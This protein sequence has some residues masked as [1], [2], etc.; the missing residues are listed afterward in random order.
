MAFVRASVLPFALVAITAASNVVDLTPDNFDDVVNGDKPAFVEFYAP[1]CGHCKS[2]A[3][4]WEE[5]ADA[6][7]SVKDVV[8]AKVD[9]SEH[10]DLGS[11]YGVTGFP[12]L[13]FFP[14]GSTDPDDYSGARET[15]DLAKFVEDKTGYRA[16]IKRAASFVKALDPSNFDSIALDE[17]KDV[18][19]EFYA[20]WCGHCKSL[21]PKYEKVGETFASEPSVV[22]AKVDADK[23][24]DLGS[25]YDVSGFP[26]IKYF[27]KGSTEAEDYSAGRETADFI[28]FLNEKAGTQ[29]VEGGGLSDTAG[30]VDE[31]DALVEEFKTSDDK[32]SVIEKA[33]EATKDGDAFA[34][35]YVKVMKKISDGDAGYAATEIARL[36]RVLDG[37]SVK[38]ERKDSFFIRKNILKVFA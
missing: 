5:L 23:H 38:A 10:R 30:R 6:Y 22:V 35:Y 16:R 2:L 26:T 19:V 8:I 4:K 24:R 13:K 21:A 18:L 32:A 37:G 3:P 25:K 36:D 9:A 11:R 1:W 34:K 28:K 17:G 12:T 31:L 15:D 20:P 29:R 14:K 27:P 33:T 7:S